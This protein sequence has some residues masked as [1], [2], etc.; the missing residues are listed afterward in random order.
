MKD[1]LRH[2]SLWYTTSI[3]DPFHPATDK[4]SKPIDMTD[5]QIK[6]NEIWGEKDDKAIGTI[7]LR[8]SP[9][10]KTFT[11]KATTAKG[12]WMLLEDKYSK[13]GLSTTYSIFKQA[14]E[15]RIQGNGNPEPEVTKLAQ[16][17]ARLKTNKV[18]LPKIIQGMILLQAIP[19]KWDSVAAVI[20][21]RYD[22]TDLTFAIVLE[23]IQ[24]EFT[25]TRS[26]AIDRHVVN[27]L[28]TVK[29]KGPNSNWKG[30]GNSNVQPKQPQQDEPEGKK[31]MRG[32]HTGKGKG[33]EVAADE[34]PHASSSGSGHRA[35]YATVVNGNSAISHITSLAA[36]QL[37]QRLHDAPAQKYTG[38]KT[39]TAWPTV[40][41][42]MTL[43]ERLDVPKTTETIWTLE[44]QYLSRESYLKQ[45]AEMCLL[46][47]HLRK[48][49]RSVTPP[50]EDLISMGSGD[51]VPNTDTGFDNWECEHQEDDHR[52]DNMQVPLIAPMHTITNI[53]SLQG[54]GIAASC[55]RYHVNFNNEME[56]KNHCAEC[57]ACKNAKINIKELLK[58]NA[59]WL[60]DS[61]ASAHFT[62]DISEFAKY[63]PQDDLGHVSTAC[64]ATI[65]TS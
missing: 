45:A 25:W 50:E 36:V 17:L 35:T 19:K 65:S 40:T 62:S 27:K 10:L 15:F 24:T 5:E 58:Y 30:K 33:K 16:L 53:E 44:T 13:E 52:F 39:A 57:K 7:Q 20:L 54:T 2:Q 61:G 46:D 34:R 6:E 11:E 56:F 63:T 21:Q 4:D 47:P 60:L 49:Q 9:S 31:K 1:W 37:L 51:N 8:L 18:I 26:H 14:V 23:A 42:A 29:K 59:L 48:K 28:S 32:K 41:Q 3:G 64:Q 38:K 55:C 12:I 43:A 22:E